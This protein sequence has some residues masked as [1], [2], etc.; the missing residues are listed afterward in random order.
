MMEV[1]EEKVEDGD[2]VTCVSGVCVCVVHAV[3]DGI[4]D[5]LSVSVIYWL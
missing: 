1:A 4:R 5:R 3:N 2:S